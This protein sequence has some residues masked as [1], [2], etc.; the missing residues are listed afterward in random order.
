[1]AEIIG[2]ALSFPHGKTSSISC[3]ECYFYKKTRI[4]Y[5]KSVRSERLATA[6]LV[7][8]LPVS[9]M[10]IDWKPVSEG[11]L[12]IKYHTWNIN[13][14]R[15]KAD[16]QSHRFQISAHHCDRWKAEKL[17][18]SK[19]STITDPILRT[20]RGSGIIS[21]WCTS[22]WMLHWCKS[23]ERCNTHNARSCNI[24]LRINSSRNIVVLDA[25]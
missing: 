13:E 23:H 7:C 8:R 18:F 2:R 9:W 15:M 4:Q 25:I 11:D 24:D 16:K 10:R 20:E 14:T 22:W 17:C 3:L 21:N 1:M 6:D 12:L 5:F 19:W